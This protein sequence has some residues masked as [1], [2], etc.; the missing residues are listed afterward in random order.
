MGSLHVLEG[1]LNAKRYIKDLEQHMLSSR[2]RRPCQ[3]NCVFQ[4]ERQTV[5]VL[6]AAAVKESGCLNCL[7]GV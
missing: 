1:K 3:I 4:Q 7:P 2:Q 5:D 6:I